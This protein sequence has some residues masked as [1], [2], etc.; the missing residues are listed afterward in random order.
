VPNTRL[1]RPPHL[2]I[3]PLPLTAHHNPPVPPPAPLLSGTAA[4]ILAA[5]SLTEPD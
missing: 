5:Q 3:K 1:P 2:T 4:A